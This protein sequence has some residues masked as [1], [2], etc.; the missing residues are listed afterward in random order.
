M[1]GYFSSYELDELRAL[2]ESGMGAYCTIKRN[3]TLLSPQPTMPN[4]SPLRCQISDAKADQQI[5]GADP[6]QK[7][8]KIKISLPWNCPVQAL[9]QVTAENMV[10]GVIEGPVQNSPNFNAKTVCY[11]YALYAIDANG[12]PG[13]PLYL[14]FNAVVTTKDK[15]VTKL[16]NVGAMIGEPDA[17]ALANYGGIVKHVVKLAPQSDVNNVR[18]GDQLYIQSWGANAVDSTKPLYV[19]QENPDGP[20]GMEF[21]RLVISDKQQR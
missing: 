18:P 8:R 15:A 2:S 20:L 16:S 1:V 13:A 6:T 5:E 11:A 17:R 10:Y 21:H 3:N 4:G 7:M 12:N 14:R 9:D 19:V